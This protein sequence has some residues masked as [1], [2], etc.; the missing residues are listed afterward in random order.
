MARDGDNEGAD[1]VR[2]VI[3]PFA[4]RRNG[5]QFD[6]T[7]AGGKF[8]GLVEQRGQVRSDWDGIWYGRATI[9]K[10]GW[11]AE[12]A[13]PFKTIS[14]NPG[15]SAAGGWGFNVEREI[16]RRQELVRWSSPRANVPITNLAEAGAIQGLAGIRQG[17]GLT[18][19]PYIS[20]RID[21]DDGGLEIKPGFD[22]FYKLT[23][24]TTLAITVNT[25]FAEA[26]VDERV[27]NLTRFPVF[28]PEKRAFFLQDATVFSFGGI[29]ESPLPFYSRRIGIVNGTKKDILA[30]VRVTGREGGINFGLMDVQMHDDGALGEKNLSVGR[31]TLN[32]LGESSAGVFFT[33]GDPGTTGDNTLVGGDFNYRTSSLFGD[34][35]LEAHA[36]TMGTF[37][38]MGPSRPGA[39]SGLQ[40]DDAAFG[41]RISYPNDRWEWDIFAARYGKDFNPALGFIERPGTYEINGDI[42][43]R[44]RPDGYIRRIDLQ[45]DQSVFLDLDGNVQT[46]EG[47]LPGLELENRR[48]DVFFIE[49][50][51]NRDVLTEPFEIKDG[52]TIPVGDYRFNRVKASLELAASRKLSPTFS[53]RTGDY[54]TGTRTDYAADLRWRPSS[55]F[56]GSVGYEYEGIDLAEGSF[57]VR[58]IRARADVLFSP[59][60]S[61][62]NTVQYDNDSEDLGFNSRVRWELEPGREVFFVVNQGYGVE[63]GHRFHSTTSDLTVKVGLTFRF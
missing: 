13:I 63:D 11:T 27:V 8:D 54:Y 12:L 14:F 59:S 51:L 57:V 33:H 28:F 19:K 16:R 22:L 44:W 24:S 53:F 4:D 29:N 58:V 55:Q 47:G 50:Q 10:E 3:D 2:I 15:A 56:F 25:D 41:G 46:Q 20:T 49:Y 60:L 39:S 31:V 36:W 61:W 37:S 45:A 62:S 7:A 34:Q 6:L 52:L 38:E 30:G 5:Y 26:E 42:R 32:V 48:G 17:L 23:T 9:D 21:M 40:G 35:I 1:L 18:L 43:Y